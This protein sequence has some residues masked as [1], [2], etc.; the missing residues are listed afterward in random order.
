[1]KLDYVPGAPAGSI[2]PKQPSVAA[3]L[4][5]ATPPSVAHMPYSFTFTGRHTIVSGVRS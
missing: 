4:H 1:M 3:A 2:F 5:L